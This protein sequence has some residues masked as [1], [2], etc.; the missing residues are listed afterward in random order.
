MTKI[1]ITAP[2]DWHCHFRDASF[3]ARTANDCAARFAR[4]IVMP[5]LK[6]PVITP[7]EAD[8]Y[9]ER[10]L[11]ACDSTNTFNPLM[12]L[13]LSANTTK[14]MIRAAAQSAH[15][16]ACKLYPSGV[17]TNSNSGVK[18]IQTI[19][20][21]LAVMEECDLPLLVHGESNDPHADVFDR[22]SYLSMKNSR[23]LLS[24]FLNYGLCLNIFRLVL[25]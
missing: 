15:I 21:V 1:T 20:P 12:T 3:L 18:N 17:T 24:N 4:A 5:N 2:D 7:L 13:Y 14:E 11:A 25:R 16:V 10:I 6:P 23:H 22:E 19:Y 9:R 8:Q